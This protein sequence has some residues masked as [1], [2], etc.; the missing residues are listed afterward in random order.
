MDE[1]TWRGG[2]DLVHE[3]SADYQDSETA[4]KIHWLEQWVLK[5]CNNKSIRK[6]KVLQFS[7][8]VMLS[9][10]HDVASIDLTG[11]RILNTVLSNVLLPVEIW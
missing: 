11:T 9:I 7:Q 6:N 1:S 4:P 8:Q 5:G 10:L 2:A 3:N